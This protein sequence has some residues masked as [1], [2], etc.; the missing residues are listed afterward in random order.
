MDNL[1][2]TITSFVANPPFGGGLLVLRIAFISFS[3]MLFAGI[4]FCLTRSRWLQY[5]F[6]QDAA[7][8]LTYRPFGVKKIVKRWSKIMARLDT[9]LES[10]YKLALIEADTM[11][12]DSLRRMGYAGDM[13]GER[14]DKLTVATLSNIEDIKRAHRVRN[15]VMHDPSY[16]LSLDEVR[17]LLGIFEQAFRDLQAF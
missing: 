1:I 16:T 10:E 12:D 8:F 2:G 6:F 15:T 5:L 13:L 3:S 9:G 14:L 11:M 4:I 7:E 17:E